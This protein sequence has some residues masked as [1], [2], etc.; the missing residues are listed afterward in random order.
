M[1]VFRKAYSVAGAVLMLQFSLQLYFIAAAALTIFGADDNSKAVYSAFKDADTFAGLHAPDLAE[2]SDHGRLVLR[3]TL[4][5]ADDHLDLRPGAPGPG[6]VCACSYRRSSRGRAARRERADHDRDW[7][8]PDRA[9]LGLPPRHRR[10]SHGT[11]EGRDASRDDHAGSVE[12]T[13]AGKLAP[14]PPLESSRP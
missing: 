6:P 10:D 7:W 14:V 13:G 12:G 3:V 11:V 2:R 5:V 9:Q 8:V 4:P 1:A